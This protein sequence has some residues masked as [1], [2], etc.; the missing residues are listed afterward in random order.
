MALPMLL[1]MDLRMEKR[2]LDSLVRL[3]CPWDGAYPEMLA[4]TR[5]ERDTSWPCGIVMKKL[6]GLPEEG[7]IKR[8]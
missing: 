6:N 4:V 8:W 7:V 5:V 2:S 1:S 3:A